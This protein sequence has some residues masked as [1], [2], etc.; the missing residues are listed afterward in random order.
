MY[1]GNQDIQEI[2][3]NYWRKQIGFVGQDIM[4]FSGTIRDNVVYGLDK[5]YSDDNLWAALELAN[6]KKFVSDMTNG[7]DTEVGEHGSRLSGGQRQRL[8]IARAFLREPKILILDEATASLDSESESMIQKSL[9]KLM[10]GRTTLVI[11]HR[12]STIIS[13]DLIYFI[14]DGAISG[15]GNHDY[16]INNHKLYKEYVD[17]Q[18][19]N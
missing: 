7:L 19:K 10:K 6:A 8:A 4:I 3:L 9:G 14:E 17:I 1:I 12:L 13:A 18:L 16:L 2:N 5:N 11:A 15:V